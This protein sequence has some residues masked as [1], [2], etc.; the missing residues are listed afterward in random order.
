MSAPR[1]EAAVTA[2][3]VAG[4]LQV[5]G[6]N[7]SNTITIRVVA[8]DPTRLEVLDLTT[9]IGTFS[10]TGLT[11]ILV[12][13]LGG[14][15][16][17]YINRIKGEITERAVLYGGD[18]N[19]GIRGGAGNDEAYGGPGD[20]RLEWRRATATTA[21]T[22]WRY[23]APTPRRFSPSPRTGRACRSRVTSATCCW[24]S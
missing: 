9:V 24:I 11:G 10:R 19:D 4:T 21:L 6:D 5:T 7:L 13:S 15:D 17:I 1:A 22:R 20:D 3:I 16:G 12:D 2:S 23:M 8:G 18:G 14:E